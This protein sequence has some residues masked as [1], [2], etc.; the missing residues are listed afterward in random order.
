MSKKTETDTV[1]AASITSNPEFHAHKHPLYVEAYQH[2]QGLRHK[3]TLVSGEIQET[4]NRL[5]THRAANTH[6]A[7]AEALAFGTPPP[8]AFGPDN[9]EALCSERNIIVT[10]IELAERRLREIEREVSL[11]LICLLYTSPSP[12][13]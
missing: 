7:K 4:N 13:D 3:L 11:D 9:L 8:I 12:R 2:I 5:A 6:R 1:D 10:A